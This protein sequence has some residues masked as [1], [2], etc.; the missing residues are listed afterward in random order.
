MEDRVADAEKPAGSGDGKAMDA[1]ALK[2]RLGLKRRRSTNFVPGKAAAPP[3][4]Q[5]TVIEPVP[6]EIVKQVPTAEDIA[7]ARERAEVALAAEGPAVEDF[8]TFGQESTPLPAALP[9][10]G[11]Q[12]I[13]AA[14]TYP[15]KGNDNLKKMLA[16][17]GIVGLVAFALG[18]SCGTTGE[19]N[20]LRDRWIYE[21]QTKRGLF[22]DARA[23]DGS[24]V[25]TRIE[26]L[27]EALS[28]TVKQIDAVEANKDVDITALDEDFG[29]LI[30]LLQAY[31][32]DNVFID[33]ISVMGEEMHNSKL[34]RDLVTYAGIT[35]EMHDN[36]KLL[37]EESGVRAQMLQ[38]PATTKR[39]ILSEATEEEVP[40]L[41]KVPFSSGRWVKDSGKPAQVAGTWQQMVLLV[42]DKEPKQVQTSAIMRLDLAQ[43][44]K[45]R[46]KLAQRVNVIRWMQVTRKL[47]GMAKG[48]NWDKV[49]KL[50]NEWADKE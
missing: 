16:L 30:P 29:K 38:M 28:A 7:A 46:V 43:L 22:L 34:M 33:P 24:K 44:Y 1:A 3:P 35:K 14:E 20:D 13:G 32:K 21:A 41:G 42:G 8:S 4:E 5:E 15:G 26:E 49:E 27:R 31:N 17:A 23:A 18:M 48:L 10:P 11:D 25:L 6:E 2:A 12:A 9:G 47:D 39:V 50:I 19:Q 40:D 37:L 45:E 36:I